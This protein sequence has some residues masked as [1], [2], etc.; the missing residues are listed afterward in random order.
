ML[1]NVKNFWIVVLVESGIP[2]SIDA[3][4]SFDQAR[5]HETT[6]RSQIS[7]DS[8]EVGV[9]ELPFSNLTKEPIVLSS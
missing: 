8:D 3:F 4:A 6:L 1:P 5:T 2:V 7:Q 9:F